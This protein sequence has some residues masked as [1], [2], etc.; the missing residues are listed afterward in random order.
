MLY[1]E[2][3]WIDDVLD[4][5]AVQLATVW[6]KDRILESLADDADHMSYPPADCFLTFRPVNFPAFAPGVS[7]GGTLTTGME[8]SFRIALFVRDNSS[9]ELTDRN[10]LRKASRNL[11]AESRKLAKCLQMFK[12]VKPGG[13]ICILKEPMRLRG[14][15]FGTRKIAETTWGVVV[16]SWEAR[17]DADLS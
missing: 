3:C 5:L 2:H 11:T 8:G 4:A 17:F 12:P 6:P 16:T 15:D 14:L 7:G 10:L 1:G 13:T 9:K